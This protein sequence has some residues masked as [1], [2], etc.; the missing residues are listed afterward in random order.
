MLHD[1]FFEGRLLLEAQFAVK[2]GLLVHLKLHFLGHLSERSLL[3]FQVTRVSYPFDE[4]PFPVNE[5]L[6]IG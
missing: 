1:L 6:R 3:E 4:S 2:D 5:R